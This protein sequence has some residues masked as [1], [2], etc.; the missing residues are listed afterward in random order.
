MEKEFTRHFHL[1]GGETGPEGE[2]PLALLA[3]RIIEMATLHADSLGVGYAAMIKENRAWVLSRLSVE[4]A[5]YPRVNERYRITTWVENFNRRFSER[6]FEIADDAGKPI[7]YARTTWAAIDLASRGVG[8]LDIVTRLADVVIDR[9]CPID[10]TPRITLPDDIPA[11]E[12]AYRFTYRDIDFNRHVNSVA[13][14]RLL[15]D[16]WPLEFHDRYRV[17]RIDTVYLHEA[18]YGDTVKLSRHDGGS[19]NTTIACIA[20]ADRQLTRMRLVWEERENDT[21]N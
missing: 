21:N 1:T 14:I 8:D 13:Y 11:R 5:R 16:A 18:R 7:G 12:S 17:K 10:K 2:M 6:N 20:A 4:V 15:L 19:P 9:Q 3:D